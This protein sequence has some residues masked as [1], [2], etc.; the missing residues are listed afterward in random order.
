MSHGWQVHVIPT[1]DPTHYA[2]EDCWCNPSTNEDGTVVHHSTDNREA[3]ETG[4][5]KPS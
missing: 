2:T 4:E 5:R 1:E 3:F